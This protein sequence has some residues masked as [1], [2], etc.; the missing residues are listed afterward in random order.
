MLNR[1]ILVLFA[2]VTINV[3]Y[4]Q[5]VDSLA[6][7]VQSKD[8]A[9]EITNTELPKIRVAVD[10]GLSNAAEET[11]NIFVGTDFEFFDRQLRLGSFVN[12]EASYFISHWFGLG[13]KWNRYSAKKSFPNVSITDSIGNFQ[14]GNLQAD[15]RIDFVGLELTARQK[16]WDQKDLIGF[17]Q[18]AYGKFWFD[19]SISVETT[20]IGTGSTNGLIIGGGIDL[21]VSKRVAIGIKL[22]CT[23][24]SASD[25]TIDD[26]VTQTAIVL[27]SGNEVNLN[28]IDFGLGARLY[29]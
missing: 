26:G 2:L 29:F 12:V 9:T 28:K 13:A 1:L 14:E 11:N 10:F 15:N 24:A 21:L 5:A 20:S 4:A 8:S 3:T 17:V 16:L 18:V 19:E 22:S 7:E 6:M 23:L 25:L 27:A